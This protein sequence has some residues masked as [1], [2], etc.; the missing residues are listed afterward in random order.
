MAL[1]LE[2]AASASTAEDEARLRAM[3]SDHFDF[4]WRSVRR[5]GMREAEADDATQQAFIVASRK[6]ASIK[7][8]SER[9]FLFGAAM[10]IV[11]NLKRSA[12]RRSELAQDEIE[13]ADPGALQDELLEQRRARALLDE[14]VAAMPL[15]ERTVFV[16]FELEQM[17]MAAIAAL[18]EIPPG[19]VASRLRRARETFAARFERYRRAKEG[20]T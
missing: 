18:L 10:R 5:L 12:A 19:T 2:D 15:D 9:S 3:M 1:P 16:L 4:V 13:A 7:Q 8:G 20:G 11:S 14:A 6:L 17:T